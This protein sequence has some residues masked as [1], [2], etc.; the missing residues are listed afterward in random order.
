M[1][2]TILIIIVIAVVLI[3]A[4]IYQSLS[5]APAPTTEN[6]T[7]DSAA[8]SSAN[9][10]LQNKE[11]GNQPKNELQTQDNLSDQDIKTFEQCVAA[12]KKIIGEKPNRRCIVN[13]DLAYIEI[14]KCHAPTGESMDMLEAQ[15]IF[16]ASQCSREGSAKIEH[17]CNENTGTWWID[18]LAY[19]K[20]CNPACVINV[21]TKTAEVNWRCTGAAPN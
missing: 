5:V 10:A 6:K 20:G 8:S 9:N 3:A 15:R 1:N 11:D 14:E 17:F 12:G 16:D 4:G 2:K 7:A 13:D 21:A 19:R 18:I